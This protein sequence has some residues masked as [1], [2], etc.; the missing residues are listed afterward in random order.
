VELA[1][2]R[3]TPVGTAQLDE[4]LRDMA[5]AVEAANE[6]DYTAALDRFY[7][8]IMALSDNAT[9]HATHDSLLGPV[10]RLRRIAMS[11]PGRMETSYRQSMRIRDAIATGDPSGPA[12]MRE[13]LVNAS[14]A[15]MD[16]LHMHDTR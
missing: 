1:T 2:Q 4:V 13:Q 5:S 16:V 12:L 11:L 6:V 8:V 14:Q 9:L 15:V 3:R 7:A 10:R